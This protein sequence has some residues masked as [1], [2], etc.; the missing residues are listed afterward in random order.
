MSK[1][2]ITVVNTIEFQ[3]YVHDTIDLIDVTNATTPRKKALIRTTFFVVL[4]ILRFVTKNC[5][6]MRN[7][8]IKNQY[9]K[10]LLPL[11]YGQT[12]LNAL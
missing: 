7:L 11:G 4:T 6:Q 12:I 10:T 9:K 3:K 5:N 1:K 2:Y 8:F